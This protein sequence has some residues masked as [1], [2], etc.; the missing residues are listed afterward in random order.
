MPIF[1]RYKGEA[2]SL[3]LNGQEIVVTVVEA[4][5]GKARI[6]I[7]ASDDTVMVKNELIR[8]TEILI[9]APTQEH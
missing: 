4:N 7:Q 9:T 8:Q 1:D 2:I 5:D 3:F 6:E